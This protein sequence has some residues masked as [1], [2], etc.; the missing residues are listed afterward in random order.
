V[1]NTNFAGLIARALA[2]PDGFRP[3]FCGRASYPVGGRFSVARTC[4]FPLA[5]DGAPTLRAPEMRK[6]RDDGTRWGEV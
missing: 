4:G 6:W 2:D 1:H 3:L 5:G